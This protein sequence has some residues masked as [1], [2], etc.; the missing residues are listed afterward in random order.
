M[1]MQKDQARDLS[2]SDNIYLLKLCILREYSNVK[3]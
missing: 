3:N 1:N 2:V